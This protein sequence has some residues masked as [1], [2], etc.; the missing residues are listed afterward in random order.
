MANTTYVVQKGDTLTRIAVMH[1]TTVS[2]LVKL[3][4]ISNPNY[5]VVGQ[6]LV[7]SGEAVT[8]TK[9]TTAAKAV[10]KAFGLQSN[11]DRTIYATWYWDRDQTKDYSVRWYY[12]TGDGT[13]FV[14]QKTTVE[15][16]Q[17][18]YTAPENAIRVR[19]MVKP[20]ST[21]Y[22]VR[23]RDVNYWNADWSTEAIYVFGEGDVPAPPV[24]SVTIDK[25][26]LTAKL[27][28]L[29]NIDAD[30]IEF[31][32]Y[33]D[34]SHIVSWG[35]AKIVTF[36]ASYSCPV[37]A[38]GE[39][40]VQ[41]RAWRGEVSST[42]SNYS[43]NMTTIPS[44]PDGIT[45]CRANTET[46]AYLEWAE[47]STATSYDIEYTTEKT[48]F[49]TSDQVTSKTGIEY[50]R[51]EVTGLEKGDE[52]F[53][54]VRAVNS[55]GTSGWTEIKSVVIGKT[56]AAPTTWSSTT[57][58]IIGDPLTLYW[59]HNAEDESSQTFADLE[60]YVDGV[61]ETYT[62]ENTANEEEKDKTSAYALDTKRFAEG[63]K[64]LWR[65][66]TAGITKE[67]GEWSTQRT[68]DIYAPPTFTINVTNSR[69]D[70]LET[71][72]SFPFYI[73]GAA[74]PN[75]QTPVGY[76][77]AIVANDGYET[78]DD[79]GNTKLIKQGEVVYSKYYSTS[80]DLTLEMLPGSVDL[81]NN[82][83]YT[84][85]GVVSMDSGLTATSSSDFVVAW[86]DETLTPNAEI[87][88]DDDSYAAIIRPYCIDE[89]GEL[90]EGVKLSV[91]RREFDG[92]F[93]KIATDL[94]NTSST[95]ITDPHPALDYARYRIVAISD[96][97]G[98]V[99]YYDVPGYPVGG[100]AVVIQWDEKW[101]T[102]DSSNPDE[103]DQ[104]S[105]SGS[106]I[107]LPY[108]I[109]VSDNHDPDVALIEYIGRAHPVGYYGTQVGETST[110]NVEI[111]KGD[112][113]TLYALRRLAKWLG[114]VY[115][116]EPSGSGYWAN[117]SVS[118][119]QKHCEMTIPVTFNIT[120]VEGGM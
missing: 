37:E 30:T 116:R 79:I 92:G 118:F 109:D 80:E 58:A 82:I 83:R 8:P 22:K 104:R 75:T 101:T 99:G 59:V 26:T 72:E 55:K 24:P 68:I 87:G 50:P 27:D 97:T 19:F 15:E 40:K 91:Y 23:N 39:Y 98:A 63:A 49:D 44:V 85:T 11:T 110:W 67:Y 47:V 2:E 21:T 52:Y 42:W 5:I 69:G 33:K 102:F 53:F 108:N 17:S 48:Y 117:I 34:N 16:R 84:V 70:R 71:V 62:I 65:V 14:A 9:T 112:E 114:N 77:V 36:H 35:K 29:Q 3:N 120:R 105:W 13:W 28:N 41:C 38:G 95:Y 61:K 78:V 51:Y 1:N 43:E 56:P 32:V 57:T 94:D 74:G 81:E 45:T 89:N 66:R 10:I 111:E 18:L 96:T 73:E 60:L 113:E 54:R 7:I 119:S 115:V 25:F 86:Q 46:S 90:I 103:P 64:I 88:I 106:L 6:K 4:D 76:H 20:N 31:H 100:I 107:K 93:T 12:D